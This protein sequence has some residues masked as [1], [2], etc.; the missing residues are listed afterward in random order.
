MFLLLQGG[1]LDP[2]QWFFFL[3]PKFPWKIDGF[4]IHPKHT[5]GFTKHMVTWDSEGCCSTEMLGS[6]IDGI[7]CCPTS[8][9]WWKDGEFPMGF[10]LPSRSLTWPLK[11]YLPNRKLV[12]QPP[13]HGLCM[14]N[15]GGVFV[16]N[17]LV[18]RFLETWVPKNDEKWVCANQPNGKKSN[19]GGMNTN[20][21]RE[22]HLFI[23]YEMNSH[24]YI[25]NTL[26]ETNMAP[27]NWWFEDDHFLSRPIFRC[28]LL[29][30]G[31]LIN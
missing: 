4:T 19:K 8:R 10:H 14:L 27:E 12:F 29:V 16:K 26:P 21:R 1:N 6:M 3:P 5:G 25:M 31:S 9:G 11:S 2:F 18:S 30:L 24:D 17:Q 7:K 20:V 22:V 23:E 13:F 15:F 28:E